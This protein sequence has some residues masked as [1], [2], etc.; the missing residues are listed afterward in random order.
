MD[1]AAV[2]MASQI[3][4]YSNKQSTLHKQYPIYTSEYRDSSYNYYIRMY[5]TIALPYT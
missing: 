2:T 4:H 1:N 5:Y 3:T